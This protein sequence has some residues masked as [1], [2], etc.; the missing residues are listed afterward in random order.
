[1]IERFVLEVPCYLLTCDISQVAVEVAY[2][3]MRLERSKGD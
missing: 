1:M 3:G 2:N